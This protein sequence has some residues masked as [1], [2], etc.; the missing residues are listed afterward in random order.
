MKKAKLTVTLT[1]EKRCKGRLN[2]PEPGTLVFKWIGILPPV[3]PVLR[4]F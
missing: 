2:M 1:C 3:C 4:L